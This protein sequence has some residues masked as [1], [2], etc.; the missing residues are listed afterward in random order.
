MQK[1]YKNNF[2]KDV[3]NHIV[4]KFYQHYKCVQNTVQKNFDTHRRMSVCTML[5]LS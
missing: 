5:T 1:F 4:I 2:G 3:N